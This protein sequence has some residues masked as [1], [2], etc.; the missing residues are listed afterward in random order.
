MSHGDK[1]HSLPEGFVNIAH[2]PNSEHAAIA[3]RDKLIWGIQFH[4]EVTHSV[5]GKV[6]LRNFVLKTCK[7][8]NDWSMGS[9]LHEAIETIRKTVGEKG[10]CIG[11]VSGGVD[12]S[13]GAL[14]LHRAIGDRFHAVFVD[15]GL[16][17][18]DEAAEVMKRLT[19]GGIQL[20]QVDARDFFLD[21]LEGVE[22]PEKKRKIIGYNFIEVFEREA[23]K[24]SETFGPMEFL[25]QGT[26]YPDVIESVS[27]KG[28]SA[29]IKTHHNVGGLKDKMKL[30]LVEPLVSRMISL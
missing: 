8:S 7:C 21:A 17:R 28:P 18:K 24:L 6:I 11:A 20:V 1:L 22:D 14:L 13:V 3:N 30:K 12:S 2:S 23:T 29:T 27:F 25:M 15:N 9:Y 10:R 4:P 5:D 26:L 16:L 19:E